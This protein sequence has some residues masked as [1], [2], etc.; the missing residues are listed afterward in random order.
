MVQQGEEGTGSQE[1]LSQS[2]I[3]LQLLM[4]AE[5]PEDFAKQDEGKDDRAYFIM[6]KF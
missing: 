6:E 1:L 2:M 3:D 5:L 4:E